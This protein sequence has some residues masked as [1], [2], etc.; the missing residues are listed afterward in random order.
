M[1]R[2]VFLGG[3]TV[4]SPRF[5]MRPVDALPVCRCIPLHVCR[6]VNQHAT[7][8]PDH[9]SPRDALG[10]STPWERSRS[11]K[12]RGHLRIECRAL[13]RPWGVRRMKIESD[14]NCSITQNRVWPQSLTGSYRAGLVYP[15]TAV[16][17]AFPACSV[18][19]ILSPKDAVAGQR[20][21][22]RSQI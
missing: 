13:V 5:L 10:F 8:S 9:S 19:R 17:A 3:E 6:R 16:S 22:T 2:L 20:N 18:S 12:S 1:E 21:S 7:R 15:S 14:P 4:T 11:R